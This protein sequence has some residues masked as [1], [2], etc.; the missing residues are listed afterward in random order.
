MAT[1]ADRLWVGSM[2]EA[3]D[4]WLEPVLFHPFAVELA[5]RAALLRPARVLELAAGT[6]ALTKELL[7][8][9][10]GATVT[11]TDLNAAMV[12]LGSTRAPDA[13]WQQ[14]DA[15][16]LPFGDDEFDLVA[17]QFGVMFFPDRIEGFRETRRVLAPGGRLLFT[18]WDTVDANGFAAALVAGLDRAFP[19]DPP[20]FVAAVP[21]GYADLEVVEAD[22]SAAD[23]QV[24][25]ADTVVLQGRADSVTDL[26]KGFCA[27]TPLR[28]AIEARGD[29]AEVTGVVADELR[30]R[31]GPGP[32]VA[33]LAAHLVE[34]AP[35]PA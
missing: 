32:V 2:P 34:A 17:C 4:R 35:T 15:L 16:D 24:V 21:H 13:T 19:E 7:T 23:M 20:T 5:A 14:A 9:L 8:A 10:P 1:D 27:G 28:M 6:G 22:L 12:Q 26:A 33:T 3:Y 11:A 31:L 18:T 29:L 25:A 30:D